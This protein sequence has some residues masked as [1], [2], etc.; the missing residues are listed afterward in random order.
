MLFADDE[1]LVYAN[2]GHVN[3]NL[4]I[5]KNTLESRGFKINR[6]KIKYLKHNFSNKTSKIEGEVRM[7]DI[8]IGRRR[9]LRY[10]DSIIQD[11]KEL[12]KDATNRI[13]AGRVK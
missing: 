1:A 9:N 7:D 13:K 2:R 4:K 5:W 6:V 3:F 10:L 8:E 12:V 11:N